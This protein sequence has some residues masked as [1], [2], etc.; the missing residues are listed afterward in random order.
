MR[1]AVSMASGGSGVAAGLRS[2]AVPGPLQGAV[3][4]GVGGG[5]QPDAQVPVDAHEAA[6]QAALRGG[7]L[8]AGA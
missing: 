2:E 5:L 8:P 3:Q 6:G 1:A 4:G 7:G